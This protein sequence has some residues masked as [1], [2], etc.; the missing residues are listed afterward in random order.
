MNFA[1]HLNRIGAFFR[2]LRRLYRTVED[3]RIIVICLAVGGVALLYLDQGRDV[4]RALVD[5]ANATMSGWTIA[6]DAWPAFGRWAAFLAACVWSGI[7]AWYWSNL[8]YKTRQAQQQPLWFRYLRR[9]FGIAPLLGAIAAM[10]LSARHGLQDAWVGMACFTLAAVLLFAFFVYRTVRFGAQPG[11]Q[12]FAAIRLERG[13]W[14]FIAATVVISVAIF[15]LL[16]ISGLR[17]HFAWALGP[18][19]L[20]YGAIGCII[21]I[22][23][24][25]I[26]LVRQQRIPIVLL[27]GIAFV[28]FSLFNDNHRVRSLPATADMSARPSLEQALAR[29]EAGRAPNEPM[30]LVAAAGGASRAAYWTGTVLRALDE[31]SNGKFSD[32]VFAISSVSGGSLGAIGYAAW[33]ADRPMDSEASGK[34]A[35]LNFVQTFFGKDYLSPAIGGLLFTD[36]LQRFLPAPLLPDRAISLEEAFEIG[37]DQLATA[38]KQQPCPAKGRLAG[39]YTGIWS[40]SR[41]QQDDGRWVPIVL[42]NGT[43]VETGKR[44]VTAPIRIETD[45]FEDTHDFYTLAPAPIRASTAVLNSARFTI[46]SPP[47]RLVNGQSTSGRI[48]DGG[49]FENGGIETV[50]DLARYLKRTGRTRKIV[51][52]EILNDDTMGPEDLARHTGGQPV[53]VEPAKAQPRSPILI[54]VTSIIG[55]LYHTRGARGVLGA[56]RVSDTGISGL[57]N[58]EFHSF[59]LKPLGNDAYTA[60]SWV[61]SLGTLDAMDV[62]FNVDAGKLDEFLASRHYTPGMEET[63]TAD[64]RA[65]IGR[66][67]ENRRQLDDVLKTLNTDIR[68]PMLEATIAQKRK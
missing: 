22:T 26:F 65:V 51:I 15:V 32:H 35:R 53:P 66:A 40:K 24:L 30:I 38:C 56:K 20:A 23:S 45:A 62:T 48:I 42:A 59:D 11:V 28:V 1:Q 34:Q 41:L 52:I 18:A 46:V 8:L 19:A 17:T 13:D 39:E 36:L 10:W 44:I 31:R 29:W 3:L 16:W 7:N 64:L 67:T 57:E 27:G 9:V 61:L 5:S 55:G 12:P 54:E 21:P 6:D 2:R 63:M 47:G 49:Y 50:Y 68:P 14:A 43:Y 25:L 4:V 58:A 37:W 60:M 33:L